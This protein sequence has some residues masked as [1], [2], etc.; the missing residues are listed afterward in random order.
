MARYMLSTHSVG[1]ADR[2]D[3]TTA[4]SERLLVRPD[5]YVAWSAGKGDLRAALA[6][7]CGAPAYDRR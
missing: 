2:V 5:G 1:W 3:H 6:R 7:W 4:G